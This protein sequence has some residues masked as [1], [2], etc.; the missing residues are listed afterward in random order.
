MLALGDEQALWDSFDRRVRQRVRKAQS[1]EVVVREARDT[2]DF[3]GLYQETYANQGLP[4]PLRLEQV[5][6]ALG[7]VMRTGEVRIFIAYTAEGEAAAGLVVGTDER[8]AYFMLAGSH[9]VHRKTDAMSLLWWEVIRRYSQS[10]AEVD[11]VGCGLPSVDRFKDAFHPEKVDHADVSGWASGLG[12]LACRGAL[13]V[14]RWL[15]PA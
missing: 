12:G 3:Y 5:E 14:Q 15:Q 13:A 11:L 9:S 2:T 4:M 8:R 10:H 6:R 7:A 1:L